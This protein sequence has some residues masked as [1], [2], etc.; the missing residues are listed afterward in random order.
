[1]G[2][3]RNAL[4]SLLLLST[5]G[6]FPMIR[7]IHNIA[8]IHL[9][10]SNS[11]PAAYFRRSTST[12]SSATR[13]LVLLRSKQQP[14]DD[15]EA[16]KNWLDRFFDPIISKYA[17]LPESDQSMLASIYQSAYFMV[18]VYVGIVMVKVYKHSV[19]SGGGMG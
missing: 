2:K 6:A 12:V 11:G 16:N 18:C 8:N 13:Q 15:E 10:S 14:E 1:M 5:A 9:Y 3:L 4:I 17:E 19:E 7:T